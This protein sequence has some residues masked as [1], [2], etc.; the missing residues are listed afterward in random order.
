MGGNSSSEN[1]EKTFPYL[2]MQNAINKIENRVPFREEGSPPSPRSVTKT[3]LARTK[4]R[5]L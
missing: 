4:H 5:I 1:E 3:R 2:F